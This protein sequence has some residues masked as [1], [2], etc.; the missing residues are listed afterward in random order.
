[1]TKVLNGET[2]EDEIAVE[3]GVYTADGIVY[4]ADL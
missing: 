2:L 3:V 4:A 1:M